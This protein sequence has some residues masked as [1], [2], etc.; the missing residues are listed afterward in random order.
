MGFMTFRWCRYGQD[1]LYVEAPD[2]CEVGWWDLRSDEAHPAH[3]SLADILA[4]V[5]AEWRADDGRSRAD[6]TVR[7][8]PWGRAS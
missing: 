7:P 2:G 5:V 3:E 1:R 6:S 4:A 8:A